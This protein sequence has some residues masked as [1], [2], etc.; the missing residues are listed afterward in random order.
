MPLAVKCFVLCNTYVNRRDLLSRCRD[1]INNLRFRIK[2]GPVSSGIPS[3]LSVSSGSTDSSPEK[4]TSDPGLREEVSLAWQQKLF[5]KE[6]FRHFANSKEEDF[7]SPMKKKLVCD[8]KKL[9]T[10][11]FVPKN[12]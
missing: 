7:E 11:G 1:N 9:R 6:Q 10:E 5:S 2:I 12:R 8:A 4:T 3:V